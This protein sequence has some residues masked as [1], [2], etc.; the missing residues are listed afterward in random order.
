[1]NIYYFR[2]DESLLI[3]TSLASDPFTIEVDL[4]VVHRHGNAA[5]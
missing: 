1:M 3:L 4:A 5:L 2:Y